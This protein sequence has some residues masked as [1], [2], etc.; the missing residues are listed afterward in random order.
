MLLQLQSLFNG[1]KHELPFEYALDL[2]AVE[3]NGIYPFKEPVKVSGAVKQS[4]GVV[5]LEATVCYRYDGV[6]DRCAGDLH[7]DR[8]LKM[9]HT[10][11]VSLNHED[12]DSFVLIENYQLPLDEL[13]EEDLILDQPSKVL[14]RE[15]CR[16]LC[17]QCGKDLNGGLCGC[18]RE[19]VDPRLAVLQQLLD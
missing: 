11:V 5:T 1:E 7:Q 15:D 19:T 6:C 14:C 18:H 8:V 13:V 4:A 12:N 9:E 16:G 17:P 3:W 2:S 10:L